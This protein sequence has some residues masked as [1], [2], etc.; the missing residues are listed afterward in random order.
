MLLKLTRA[1][2]N[3]SL[4]LERTVGSP[5]ANESNEYGLDSPRD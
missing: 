5:Y 1:I 3:A 4:E 2:S